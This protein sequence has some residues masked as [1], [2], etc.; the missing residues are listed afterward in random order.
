MV[1][2]AMQKGGIASLRL[3]TIY[4]AIIKSEAVWTKLEEYNKL[5]VV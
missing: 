1:F 3:A 4:E 5:A 2:F